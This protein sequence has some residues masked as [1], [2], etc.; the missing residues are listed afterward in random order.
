M[1]K[2]NDDGDSEQNN[3]KKSSGVVVVFTWEVILGI[4]IASSVVVVA[5]IFMILYFDLSGCMAGSHVC[6]CCGIAL[7]I[8]N[9]YPPPFDTEER[10]RER[11][12]REG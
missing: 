10:E 9:A 12:D 4:V 8:P 6:D 7:W 11:D 5:I 1:V 3:K 2:L